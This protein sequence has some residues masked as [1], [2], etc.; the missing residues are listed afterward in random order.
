[1]NKGL[2]GAGHHVRIA[3]D[4]LGPRD[5]VPGDERIRACGE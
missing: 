2:Q 5:V 4:P 3:E 1:M